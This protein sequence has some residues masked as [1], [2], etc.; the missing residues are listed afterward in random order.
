VFRAI[1][2]S[3]IQP[4]ASKLIEWRFTVQMDNDLKNPAKATL[5]FFKANKWNVMQWSSQSPDLNPVEHA[6]HL[7]KAKLKANS[8]RTSRN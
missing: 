3:Q 6:F 1:F 5:Y 8:P 4:N 7:L 2:S